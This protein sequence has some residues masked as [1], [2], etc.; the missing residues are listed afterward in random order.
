MSLICTTVTTWVTK[1]VLQPVNTWATQQQEKCDKLPWWNPAKWFCYVV[2]V[3]VQVVVWVTT[4]IL[5]PIT[6]TICNVV[7]GIIGLFLLILAAAVDAV[8]QKCNLTSCVKHWFVTPTKITLISTSPS[9]TG[10]T[11]YTFS[12]NCSVTN[13]PSAVVEASNDQ[14]AAQLAMAE[15]QKLC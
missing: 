11:T 6:Q 2:T 1:E 15:C 14:E 3:T 8:C 4:K 13:K 10:K 12:C 5:V 7:T 9:P